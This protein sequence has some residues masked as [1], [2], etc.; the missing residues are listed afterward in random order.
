[1]GLRGEGGAGGGA[2]RAAVQL[3]QLCPKINADE[4]NP[5]SNLLKRRKIH[6][7]LVKKHIQ[8][9]VGIFGSASFMIK[10]FSATS[11]CSTEES[12]SISVNTNC[13]KQM[14]LCTFLG[15]VL[16]VERVRC[17]WVVSC[18]V[19][20]GRPC[21]EAGGARSAASIWGAVQ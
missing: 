2:G 4:V 17:V 16:A 9:A 19:M 1:M 21:S 13:M 14:A 11:C 15:V 7:L 18:Q 12:E 6:R 5:E 10:S 8:K 3:L 20:L